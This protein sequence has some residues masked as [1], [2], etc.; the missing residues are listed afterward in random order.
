MLNYIWFIIIDVNYYILNFR[1]RLLIF[2]KLIVAKQV[3]Y[4][5]FILLNKLLKKKDKKREIFK[6]VKINLYV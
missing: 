3:I 6:Y 1:C 4:N 2:K 5:Y